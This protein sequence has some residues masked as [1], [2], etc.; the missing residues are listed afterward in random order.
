MQTLFELIFARVITG[1]FGRHTL[2]FIYRIVGY[3]KGIDWL[4]KPQDE[5][6]QFSGGCLI[7]IVGII[8][9]AFI[10]YAIGY[11]YYELFG[12]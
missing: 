11:I 9:F 3:Q 5:M 4:S 12:F 8:V 7:H 10:V 1:F 6:E 2:L